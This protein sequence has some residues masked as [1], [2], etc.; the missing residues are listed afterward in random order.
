MNGVLERRSWRDLEDA[1]AVGL[2]AEFVHDGGI[3]VFPTE[4]SYALGADPRNESAVANI[5]RLKRRSPAKPLPVVVGTV[6]MLESLGAR[7]GGKGWLELEQAW[8]GP[9]T[10]VVPCT[11]PLAAAAGRSE[12]AVRIPGHRRLRETLAAGAMALTATSANLASEEPVLDPEELRGLLGDENCLIIDEGRLPGGPPSTLVRV[13]G[14][15]VTVLRAGALG[16]AELREL[17]HLEIDS[18][19]SASAVEIPVEETS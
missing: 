17:T 7:V 12:L 9:L 4:S 8:P 14:D 10:V 15:R 5:Y 6:S 19:F 18:S 3:V 1:S 16:L 13:D 2:L 11:R